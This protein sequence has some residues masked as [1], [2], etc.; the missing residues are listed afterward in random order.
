MIRSRTSRRECR[1]Q[2][3][4]YGPTRPGPISVPSRESGSSTKFDDGKMFPALDVAHGESDLVSVSLAVARSVGPARSRLESSSLHR[5]ARVD[6]I[7]RL[8]AESRVGTMVV[9]PPRVQLNL[10]A[11]RDQGQRNEKAPGRLLLDGSNEPLYDGD[12]RGFANTPVA[13][14]DTSTLAPALETAAPELSALV[15]NHVPVCGATCPDGSFEEALDVGR[16]GDPREH[17]EAHT[18][19]RYLVDRGHDPPAVRPTLRQRERKPRDPE[20]GSRRERRQIDVPR[21][22]GIPGNDPSTSTFESW[23][24][25]R[26]RSAL[27]LDPSNRRC[28]EPEPDPSEDVGHALATHRGEQRFQLPD[29][30]PHEIRVAVDRLH[31]PNQGPFTELIQPTHPDQERLHIEEKDPGRLLECPTSSSPEL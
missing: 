25:V 9:V 15:G 8:T 20:A 10:V 4:A 2:N 19:P 12:A 29:E 26:R 21:V 3:Q 11:R 27:S 18:S 30:I 23:L 1:R 5:P 13:R 22:P 6:L 16:R 24:I 7:G 17:R 14:P 28:A 31:G